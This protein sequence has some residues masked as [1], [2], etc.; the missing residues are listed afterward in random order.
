MRV[1]FTEMKRVSFLHVLTVP[2]AIT[3]IYMWSHPY[4]DRIEVNCEYIGSFNGPKKIYIARLH[5]RSGTLLESVNDTQ[6]RFEFKDQSDHI[7]Y[8]VQVCV[9]LLFNFTRLLPLFPSYFS[10]CHN[11]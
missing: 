6:C 1:T 3:N 9:I 10:V 2:D 8:T 11:N 4:Y 7:N 5:D